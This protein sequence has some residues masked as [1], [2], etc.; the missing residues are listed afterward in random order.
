MTRCTVRGLTR[1][2]C[3]S[4]RTVG[5][6]LPTAREPTSSRN[7]ASTLLSLD[8]S[9]K[10]NVIKNR[11]NVIRDR[12][13]AFLPLRW[14]RIRIGGGR[15]LAAV[16]VVA[17][18]FSLPMTKIAVRGFDPFVAAVGR[19]AVASVPAVLVLAATGA[20]RPT[21]DQARELVAVALGVVVGFPLLT[22]YALQY[23]ASGHG[24]VVV[25]LLP[26]ATAGVGA[27]LTGERPSGVY[28]GAGVVGLCAGAAYAVHDGGGSVHPADGLLL[29]AVLAGAVGY[30][31]GA[32]LSRVMGGW[33]VISW[34]L[35]LSSPLTWATA[36]AM[37]ARDGGIHASAGQWAA[38]GYTA[39]VSMFLGFFAWYAG[40]ARAGIARG[41]QLQ[42][43]QPMLSVLWGWPLLGERITGPALLTVAVVVAAVAVG[44]RAP[45]R[46]QPG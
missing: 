43:V 18:S 39:G 9:T 37:V 41:S 32:T 2:R 5:S 7:S 25:G 13:V 14:R 17:F 38:F 29:G 45:V 33:R 23:T 42:M 21:R 3:V 30:A 6:W 15:P 8:V 22:A 12:E 26:L 40:L 46:V 28:W 24:A 34:A 4:S 31:R 20:G 11:S 16:G 44:R 10:S 19:A 27:R 36:L 35:V 1:C